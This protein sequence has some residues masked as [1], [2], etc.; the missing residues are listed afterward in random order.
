MSLLFSLFIWFEKKEYTILVLDYSFLNYFNYWTWHYICFLILSKTTY[1][2]WILSTNTNGSKIF[3]HKYTK[4]RMWQVLEHF[5]KNFILLREKWIHM[6]LYGLK[7]LSSSEIQ[8]AI[9]SFRC[10]R[11]V[12]V[13]TPSTP[14]G[15]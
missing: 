6:G 7:Y 5:N 1:E 13:H 2:L 11:G 3:V 4:V 15:A 8:F 14:W 10:C 12:V 9:V